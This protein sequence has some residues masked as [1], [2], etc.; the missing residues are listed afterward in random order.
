MLIGGC[1]GDRISLHGVLIDGGAFGAHDERDRPVPLDFVRD[2]NDRG[3]V[4]TGDNESEVIA[5]F[6]Y[7]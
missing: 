3:S 6:L 7:V 5:L 1:I 4:N 2:R